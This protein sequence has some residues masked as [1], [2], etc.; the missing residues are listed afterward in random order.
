MG[1]LQ[2]CGSPRGQQ[3]VCWHFLSF[4]CFFIHPSILTCAHGLLRTRLSENKTATRTTLTNH[5]ITRLR[6]LEFP[7]PFKDMVLS[8]P[9]C[10]GHDS[11]PITRWGEQA[12]GATAT[13]GL[14]GIGQGQSGSGDPGFPLP[15]LWTPWGGGGASPTGHLLPC[16]GYG[17]RGST[18]GS[19]GFLKDRRGGEGWDMGSSVTQPPDL[20]LRLRQQQLPLPQSLAED[21]GTRAYLYFPSRGQES[22]GKHVGPEPWA[23]EGGSPIWACLGGGVE[24]VRAQGVAGP[25][26]E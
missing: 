17:P 24:A 3:S 6:A 2:G 11:S 19:S 1:I 8:C 21:D 15:C 10:R 23:G 25:Q 20:S 26:R 18:A 13:H 16:G 4:I 22:P 9:C 7:K 14:M 12:Q 5:H